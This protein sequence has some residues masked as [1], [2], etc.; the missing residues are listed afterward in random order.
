[1][2]S[3]DL[4]LTYLDIRGICEPVLLLLLDSGAPFTYHTMSYK[5]MSKKREE[6][7]ITPEEGYLFG[8]VPKLDYA[9]IGGHGR[10]EVLVEVSAIGEFLQDVLRP[11]ESPRLGTVERSRLTMLY[12]ASFYFRQMLLSLTGRETSFSPE[13]LQNIETNHAVPFLQN[14]EHQLRGQ[15]YPP[16]LVDPLKGQRGQ[17]TLTFAACGAAYS[18]DLILL[19]FPRLLPKSHNSCSLVVAEA[20]GEDVHALNALEDVLDA[21]RKVGTEKEFEGTRFERC[22]KLHWK[23]Y[24]RRER[25]RDWWLQNGSEM[26]G[27]RGFCWSR[28]PNA[29]KEKFLE[30]I[31]SIRERKRNEQEDKNEPVI[32]V[33]I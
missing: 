3:L 29:T 33:L 2:A 1:M 16:L 32:S 4:N 23:V 14:L 12:S 5:E 21:H 28:S 7:K 6:G 20:L 9:M 22:A 27:E 13:S 19:L 24:H 18:I 10:R 11:S 8:F 17:T 26:T 30:G 15:F 31:K 25:I